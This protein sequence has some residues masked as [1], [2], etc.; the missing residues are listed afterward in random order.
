VRT[1]RY[2]PEQRHVLVTDLGGATG[3]LYV[4][5]DRDCSGAEAVRM[6]GVL[7]DAFARRC[8]A[9]RTVEPLG[10]ASED[11]ASLWWSA[12]GAALSRRLAERPGAQ[13]SAVVAV[14]QALRALH[15]VAEAQPGGL[16]TCTRLRDAP[17]EARAAV[18]AGAHIDTLL[19]DV[20]S[21]YV[22]LLSDVAERLDSMPFEPPSLAH[23]DFKC[24][25]I[26][27]HRAVPR[28]LDLDR[29]CLA[30]PALDVGK[31]LADLAWWTPDDARRR[32]LVDA[33]RAGYGPSDPLRWERAELWAVLFRLKNIARRAAVHAPDW[34]ALVTRRVTAARQA[35][36]ATRGRC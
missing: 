33:F 1:L 25:N 13:P 16:G 15:D 27:I 31:F 14:G 6:A 8:P 22:A 20:G 21:V 2:R 36:S 9:A 4:K 23:G 35:L 17:G 19:P 29:V 12:P 7:R 10:W 18:S 24:D 34:E 5:T 32:L 28:I 30:E 3:R 26:L 11:S